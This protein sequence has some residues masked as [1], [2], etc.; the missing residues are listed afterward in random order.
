MEIMQL[1]RK[2]ASST[3]V[4]FTCKQCGKVI[5]SDYLQQGDNMVCP[6][7]NFEQEVPVM[8][9]ETPMNM[10][11]GAS[12]YINDDGGYMPGGHGGGGFDRGIGGGFGPG[13]HQHHVSSELAGRG[14]RLLAQIIDAGSSW[15]ESMHRS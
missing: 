1:P 3:G 2:I 5:K 13:G 6:H 10:P 7:C 11:P 8:R 15:L 14:E 12:Q 9:H 4:S